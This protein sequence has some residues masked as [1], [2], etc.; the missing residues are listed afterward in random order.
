M[1]LIAF[2]GPEQPL[3]PELVTMRQLLESANPI[4]TLVWRA[5]GVKDL[6]YDNERCFLQWSMGE[7]A[8]CDRVRL[9]YDE[10]WDL[11]ALDFFGHV[12]DTY[13]TYEDT[14]DA[15]RQAGVQRQRN[16]ILTGV[17]VDEVIASIEEHT[18]FTLRF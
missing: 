7:G 10:C 12:A 13:D 8:H 11:Y 6:V 18:G 16:K 17:Y 1:N 4:P 14:L 2:K 3:R 5:M 15:D 9:S